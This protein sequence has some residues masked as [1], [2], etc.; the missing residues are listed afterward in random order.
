VRQQIGHP[1]HVAVDI[2]TGEFIAPGSMGYFQRCITPLAVETEHQTRY[3]G[4]HST[5]ACQGD[6]M[7]GPLALCQEWLIISLGPKELGPPTAQGQGLADE[8]QFRQA[9]VDLCAELLGPRAL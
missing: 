2:V 8:S 6:D 4:H 1:R 7:R 5:A 9:F 3:Y